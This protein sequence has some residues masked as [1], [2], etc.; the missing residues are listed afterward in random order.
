MEKERANIERV[1]LLFRCRSHICVC[2]VLIDARDP[3]TANTRARALTH[4]AHFVSLSEE[5]HSLRARSRESVENF[6]S[7]TSY[8]MMN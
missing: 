6:C 8:E 2:L 5:K 7:I 1:G 3:L 4:S